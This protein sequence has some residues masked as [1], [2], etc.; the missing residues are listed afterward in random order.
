VI[1]DTSGNLWGTGAGYYNYGGIF[2][3]TPNSDGTW[4]E[5]SPYA[6]GTTLFS[7]YGNIIFDSAG[8]LFGAAE[9]STPCSSTYG[10]GAIYELSH[11]SSGW[12]ETTLY[13]FTGGSDGSVP[14]STLHRDSAG[15]LYATALYG[16]VAQGGFGGGSVLKLSPGS[17]GTW[18]GAVLY[19]FPVLDEGISPYGGLVADV[20]GNLY[21]TTEEGG[22]NTSCGYYPGCGTVFQLTPVATGG[23]KETVIYNFTGANGDGAFPS[24]KLVFDTAGNL[25]GTT[26]YGG[27]TTSA[28]NSVS[29]Q[30]GTVFKLSPNGNGTWTE[31]VLH[32]FTG[33]STGDGANPTT[34]LVLD[35]AGNV[36]GTTSTGGG[37]FNAGIA[38][39]LTPSSGGTWTEK[40]LHVFGGTGDIGQ[41]SST[42]IFDKSGN[43]YG[44]AGN[45]NGT[46]F[47][48]GGVYR[49]SPSGS[50][51]T[52]TVLFSF[53]SAAG[54]TGMALDNEGNLYGTTIFGGSYN[55]GLA[56]KLTPT[57]SG[58]WA[59]TVLYNFIGVNGDGA[60]PQGDLVLDSL[61]NLYGT[62]TYGGTISQSCIIYGCGTVFELMPTSSGPWH[63]RV[64]H[65]FT[66]GKDGA[67]PYSGV[68]FDSAGNLFGAA[69]VGGSGASGVVFEVK[70]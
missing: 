7:P 12:T 22:S 63:E 28:C 25:Y 21:G 58:S 31:T 8:N 53:A 68:T 55:G 54:P 60:F 16:G 59:Q 48:N 66:G 65:R 43:L 24:A 33:Y 5:T 19:D 49:L 36:Y 29:E 27:I 52:E 69:T 13:N 30:C 32:A 23:W 70:P 17:G 10:C 37:N 47:F 15:N 62:T 42:L 35:A 67:A 45:G 6:F 2:E 14:M 41:P 64:L 51:W 26:R 18:T 61:G 34:G 44:A 1:F 57:S 3:L 20:A 9:F 11:G 4:S 38:F 46:G 56:Y 40:I 50:S 39:Q